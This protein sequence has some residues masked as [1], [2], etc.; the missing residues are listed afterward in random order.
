[1]FC[2]SLW[3]L[4]CIVCPPIYVFWLP[5]DYLLITFWLPSD[6]LLITFCLP[7]DYLL[8]TLWLPSDYLL[9]TFCLPFDY[10]LITFWL[11]SGYLLITFWLPF[12]SEDMIYASNFDRQR[13]CL[14]WQWFVYQKRQ[15]PIFKWYIDCKYSIHIAFVNQIYSKK[16]LKMPKR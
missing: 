4:H 3:P 15:L 1:M 2:L 14:F 7:F 8:V 12:D 13:I 5:F 6:Y 11:P 16:R 10:L 9:I